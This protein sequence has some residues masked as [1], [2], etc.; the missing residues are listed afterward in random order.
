MD[1][2]TTGRSATERSVLK[3]MYASL[4]AFLQEL[5]SNHTMPVADLYTQYK[6]QASGDVPR[7]EFDE[8]L[9]QLAEEDLIVLAGPARARTVR[10][11]F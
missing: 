11:M 10:R 3:D 4:K 6:E 2:I 7:G 1:L 8:V 5:A 9:N